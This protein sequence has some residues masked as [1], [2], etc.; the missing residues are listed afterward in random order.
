MGSVCAAP[1]KT[2]AAPDQLLLGGRARVRGTLR[3]WRGGAAIQGKSMALP[4]LKV[5]FVPCI[6]EQGL[7]RGWR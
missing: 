2:P 1:H 4:V 7:P 6:P 5:A 3:A